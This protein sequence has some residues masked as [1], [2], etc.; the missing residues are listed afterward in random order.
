MY[1]VNHWPDT[2][3]Y[4][5]QLRPNTASMSWDMTMKRHWLL[6]GACQRRTGIVLGEEG[7]QWQ[8]GGG[9]AWQPYEG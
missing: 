1:D 5:H 7:A 8:V 9:G 2:C 3:P 4:G 6:C